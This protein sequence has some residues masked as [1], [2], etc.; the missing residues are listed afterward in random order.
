MAIRVTQNQMSASFQGDLQHVMSTMART[1]REISTG[2]K[3]Q[4]PSDDPFGASQVIGF[5]AQL[6]DVESYKAN[7]SHALGFLNTADSA[8]DGVGKSMQ[9]IRDLVVQAS[10]GT[11]DQ[12]A[13]D[14]IATE[15]TQLKEAVRD[16]I[17]GRFGAEYLFSGTTSG[18]TPYPAPGNAYAGNGTTMNRRVSPGLSIAMNMD[19]PS[20]LGTTTGALPGQMATFDLIDQIVSD[21]QTGSPASL[22][23]LR[24]GDLAALD[25]R[26]DQVLQ[27]RTTLGST[28]SRL[29]TTQD[30]LGD[31]EERLMQARSNIADVDM[32]KTYVEFQ[33][34]QSMYKAALAAGTRIMQTSILDYI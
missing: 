16:S 7:V 19:G 31:L 27:A 17:N 11:N 29:E 20:V 32:A 18:T 15:I 2:Q 21:I 3:I 25:A 23:Q 5:D 34:Q 33:N 4:N 1:Q 14:S 13:L 30:Q 6:A 26:F 22:S 28:A 9:R 12:A 24:N 8:L 10:N